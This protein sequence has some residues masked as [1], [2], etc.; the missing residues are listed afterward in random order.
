VDRRTTF[1]LRVDGETALHEFQSLPH[2]VETKPSAGLYCFEVKAHAAI[3]D[4]EMNLLRR[5]VQLNIEL[6]HSAMLHCIVQGFL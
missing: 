6:P 2:V 3:T 1:G 5:S 4:R